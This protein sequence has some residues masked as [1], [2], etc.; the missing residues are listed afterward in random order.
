MRA[1][2]F[3]LPIAPA[4]CAHSWELQPLLDQQQHCG[5]W[6]ILIRNSFLMV[7]SQR[8]AAAAGE[9][10]WKY[11]TTDKQS[12]GMVGGHFLPFEIYYILKK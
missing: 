3:E 2:R 10:L 6:A 1:T 11:Y 8:Q 9:S 7:R 12:R 4:F 5:R